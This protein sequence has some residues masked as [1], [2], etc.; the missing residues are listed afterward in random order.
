MLSPQLKT[1]S[2]QSFPMKLHVQ[3]RLFTVLHSCSPSS[4]YIFFSFHCWSEVNLIYF[5][6]AYTS[7]VIYEKW[8][9]EMKTCLKY[10]VFGLSA[11]LSTNFKLR[12]FGNPT[13]IMFHY[14]YMISFKTFL[15]YFKY[16]K[17]EI[18]FFFKNPTKFVWNC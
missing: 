5:I 15:K 14:K 13:E 1:F 10:K 12:F 18:E 2:K 11:K 8:M 3:L 16:F 17:Y 9:N 6:I 4:S 7:N